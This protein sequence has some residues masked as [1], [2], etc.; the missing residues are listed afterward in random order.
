MKKD[1]IMVPLILALIFAINAGIG[2]TL[3]WVNSEADGII[4]ICPPDTKG[5]VCG[6]IIQ[7]INP[8]DFEHG[9]KEYWNAWCNAVLG[10]KKECR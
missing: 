7:P 3:A 10:T 5:R 8:Y 2:T 1:S 9:T 6:H 4:A